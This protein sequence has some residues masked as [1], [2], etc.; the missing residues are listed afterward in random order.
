M[1]RFGT[2]RNPRE[3]AYPGAPLEWARRSR[4]DESSLVRVFSATPPLG[5]TVFLLL[6]LVYL[7]A[8]PYFDGLRSANELPR[9]LTT[10]E[11]VERGTFRLDARMGELGSRWDIATTPDGHFYQNKAPGPSLLA[12]PMYLVLKLFGFTSL[13]VSTWAFRVTVSALPAA[14][15][16][17]FFYRLSARFSNDEMARRSALAAYG[18]GSPAVP[19]AVLFMSHQPAAVSAGGA[20][21][22]AVSLVRAQVVPNRP[23]RAGL[24][25]LLAGTSVMM[26][27]QSALCAAAVGIYLIA[28]SPRRFHDGALAALGA[29]IPGGALAAYHAACFGSPLKTGYSLADPVH[30][31]GFMG[32]V[33]PSKQA[34]YHTLLDPSNGLLVLMPWVVLAP[35]GFV[36]VMAVRES[37]RRVGAEAL[38]CFV[39]LAGYLLFMGSLVPVFSRAGWCVGPR[40]M[41]VALPFVAW[42][43]VPGFALAERLVVTRIL[44]RALVVA[45]AVVFLAAATTYPHWP[46]DIRNPLYELVFRLLWNGYAV[47]SLG[48][49]V[50]LRGLWSLLP[51]YLFAGG[52]AFWLMSRGSRNGTLITALA[53]VL[54]AGIIVGQR[55]FPRTGPYADRAY[56]FVTSTWEP[57]PPPPPPPPRP[58]PPVR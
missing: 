15:F 33:G 34:F 16:L 31:Q 27:Y 25:G 52:I 48:T 18:L 28:C 35:I 20:F 57:L 37:R 45:S 9:V 58:P 56:H 54:G 1:D 39:V 47:H 4:S 3:P 7:Y 53:F 14:L 19:Y 41:T 10:Q 17:F 29:A 12:V 24:V 23:L 36:A 13:R 8:F 46:E 6:A 11:I 5:K 49:L 55:S 30:A 44:T 51:L 43:A 50:G 22:A 2:G 21:V 40:Y 32:L 38:V 42:L 26:D